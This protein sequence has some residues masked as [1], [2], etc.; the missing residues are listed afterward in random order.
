VKL[1][2]GFEEN[3]LYVI[4]ALF[5]IVVIVLTIV[6]SGRD[7]TP[8]R[9]PFDVLDDDWYWDSENSSKEEGVMGLERFRSFTY[10]CEND[11]FPAYVTVSTMKN[12]FMMDEKDLIDETEDMIISKISDQ[13]IILDKKTRLSG[14]RTL[15][16]DHNSYYFVYNNATKGEGN[17][18]E[19]IKIFGE[20]WN[21][22]KSGTS[23][24]C[25]AIAQISNTSLN[26]KN[27]DFF[28][29]KIIRDKFGTFGVDEFKG[30]D[31]LIYNI[32]CH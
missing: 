12:F 4:I 32:I 15:Y 27:Y 1:R 22:E 3:K 16:N 18:S 6:F 20:A 21:C 23:I 31:G 10:R 9:I 8:A 28:W 30:S 26:V 17:S 14:R 19:K 5:V 25:V 7:L 24:I 29:A 13:N 2:S 11:S